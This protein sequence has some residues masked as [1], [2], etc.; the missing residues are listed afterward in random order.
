[1]L[2]VDG[3]D[4]DAFAGALGRAIADG[5]L[6]LGLIEAGHRNV[7]RFDWTDTA[8]R[9]VGLYRELVA[10]STPAAA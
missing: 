6:R 1:V 5:A 3:R 7:R 4:A 9:L 8:D 10:E 2:L